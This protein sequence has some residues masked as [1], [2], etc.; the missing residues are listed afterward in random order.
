MAKGDLVAFHVP[1]V[2]HLELA[3]HPERAAAARAGMFGKWNKCMSLPTWFVWAANLEWQ[4]GNRFPLA[5]WPFGTGKTRFVL[6]YWR[7]FKLFLWYFLWCIWGK[8]RAWSLS[9]IASGVV[10]WQHYLAGCGALGVIGTAMGAT[11]VKTALHQQPESRKSGSTVKNITK[12]FKTFMT[13][14]EMLKM[15]FATGFL[16]ASTM[17]A[18]LGL[19][20]SVGNLW[21]NLSDLI[22]L[23]KKIILQ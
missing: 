11:V 12:V 18:S 1:C 21:L 22:F 17:M 8:F 6:Q 15:T 2:I 19:S 23:T 5:L 9:A 7:R 20:I 16:F 3:K 13:S 14:H 4:F 10:Q